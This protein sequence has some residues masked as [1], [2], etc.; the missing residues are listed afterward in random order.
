[1]SDELGRAPWKT[2][3]LMQSVCVIGEAEDIQEERGGR[4]TGLCPGILLLVIF[5]FSQV[6]YSYGCQI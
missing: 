1:M 3:C 4:N 2:G 5:I 6:C